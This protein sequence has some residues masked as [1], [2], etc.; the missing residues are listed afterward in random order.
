[1]IVS[2]AS[3]GMKPGKLPERE[4]RARQ[5]YQRKKREDQAERGDGAVGLG[6]LFAALVPADIQD[7]VR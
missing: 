4:E 5:G 2:V 1:M 7:K 3:H 6:V